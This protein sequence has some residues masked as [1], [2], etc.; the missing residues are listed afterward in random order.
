MAAG[1][2]QVLMR[3]PAQRAASILGQGAFAFDHAAG[4]IVLDRVDHRR[5]FIGLGQHL[6]AVTS[7]QQQTIAPLVAAH[8]DMSDRVDPQ[9]RCI[10][11]ADA[12][13]EQFDLGWHLGKQR[14]ERLVEH[15]Q[16]GQLGIAQID[17]HTR[18]IGA[19]DAR[20]AEGVLQ[21][22]AG[23]IFRP[24]GFRSFA[25]ASPHD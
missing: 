15:F 10:A 2:G 17:H 12:T 1:K 22:S 23:R 25:L 19:R 14:I 16:P 20:Q 3:S 4:D 21:Q 11:P 8:V 7:V 24:C 13:I 5:N 18:A 6:A 9:P